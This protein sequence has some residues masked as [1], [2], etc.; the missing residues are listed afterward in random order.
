LSGGSGQTGELSGA[1]VFDTPGRV[2]DICRAVRVS[3]PGIRLEFPQ[4]DGRIL[5]QGKEFLIGAFP[6]GDM[7]RRRIASI[8][9]VENFVKFEEEDALIQSTSCTSAQGKVA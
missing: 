5:G 2:E 8:Q 1:F 7:L 6:Q 3:N 4:N 9:Q